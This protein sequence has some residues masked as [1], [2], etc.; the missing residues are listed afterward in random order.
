MRRFLGAAAAVVFALAGCGG[1]SSGA[2]SPLITHDYYSSVKTARLGGTL[3]L[4]DDGCLAVRRL[5]GSLASVILPRKDSSWKDGVLTFRGQ[6]YRLGEEFY[7]AIAGE[8]DLSKIGLQVPSTC[9]VSENPHIVAAD[10]R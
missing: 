2:A 3:E 1:P 6:T 4:R 5:D 9:T 10:N 7:T 8:S